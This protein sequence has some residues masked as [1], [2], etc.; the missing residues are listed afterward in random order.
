MMDDVTRESSL[1]IKALGVVIG[2]CLFGLYGPLLFIHPL[3]WF[4]INLPEAIA[5]GVLVGAAV[6]YGVAAAAL[7]LRRRETASGRQ[8]RPMVVSAELG[9]NLRA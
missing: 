7:R 6:G 3:R 5:I 4:E 1:L 9:A 2:E 8:R